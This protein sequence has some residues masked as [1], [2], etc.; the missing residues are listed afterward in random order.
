MTNNH[1]AA[2][3]CHLDETKNQ[4]TMATAKRLVKIITSTPFLAT[5]LYDNMRKELKKAPKTKRV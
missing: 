1:I 4:V 3:L 2:Y 5:N